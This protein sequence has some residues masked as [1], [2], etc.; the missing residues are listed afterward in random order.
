[1]GLF[2]TGSELMVRAELPGVKDEDLDIT[3]DQGLLTLRGERKVDVPEGYAVHRQERGNLKFARSFTLPCKVD[4]ERTTA[5]LGNGVLT[6]VMPKAPE[7]QPR[8][9]AISTK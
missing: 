9:I 8:Q 5:N 2:D 7:D 3:L 6:M 4:A 1:V